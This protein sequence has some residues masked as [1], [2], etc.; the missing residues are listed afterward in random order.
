MGMSALFDRKVFVVS[1]GRFVWLSGDAISAR[2]KFLSTT[3]GELV[4][5]V[6]QISGLSNGNAWQVEMSD[7]D[8]MAIGVLGLEDKIVR[9]EIGKEK[10]D[11][12]TL[13][14]NVTLQGY[15]KI[16]FQGEERATQV[17]IRLDF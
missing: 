7:S 14:Q 16:R 5:T 17:P 9:K 11:T 4:H 1:T 2:L 3:P 15:A 12:I 10:V 13:Q 6:F 8:P